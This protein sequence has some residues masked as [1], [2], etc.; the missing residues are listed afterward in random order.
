MSEAEADRGAIAAVDQPSID[1]ERSVQ[2]AR[3]IADNEK[4][5]SCVR[6]ESGREP[7]EEKR[8]PLAP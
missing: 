6:P 4:E 2:F 1:D 8:R 7:R 3:R 5:A